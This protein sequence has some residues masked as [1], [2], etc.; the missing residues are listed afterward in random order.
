[1]TAAALNTLHNLHFYLD[2][3]AAIRN[4]IA[5]G[6]FETF[7][8]EFLGTYTRRPSELTDV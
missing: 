7:R 4:A 6:N 2:T 8:Q 3:M 5:F 1:M